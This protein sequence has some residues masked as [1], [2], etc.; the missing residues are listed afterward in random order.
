MMKLFTTLL[1][2]CALQAT[3]FSTVKAPLTAPT[4]TAL[5]G[6]SMGPGLM[7][8]NPQYAMQNDMNQGYN[9]RSMNNA[10]NNGMGSTGYGGMGRA[11]QRSGYGR[12]NYN[13]NY[14]NFNRNSYSPSS[15]MNAYDNGRQSYMGP[16]QNNYSNNNYN[17]NYGNYGRQMN[18]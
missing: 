2:I 16:Y 6:Y 7:Y 13:S 11:M 14:G 1:A 10:W 17:S 4:S 3:A 12:N 18:N 5:E 15:Y 9:G 8:A